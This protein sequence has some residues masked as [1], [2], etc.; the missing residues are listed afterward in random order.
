MRLG[1]VGLVSISVSVSPVIA[2][3]VKSVKSASTVK[4][5]SSGSLLFSNTNDGSSLRAFSSSSSSSSS[6]LEVVVHGEVV[7]EVTGLLD[8]VRVLVSTVVGLDV[9]TVVV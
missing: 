9:M 5:R 3:K 1:V 8:A 2:G 6:A 4:G 7:A